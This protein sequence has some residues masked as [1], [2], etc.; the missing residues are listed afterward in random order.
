MSD[1]SK[2]SVLPFFAIKAKI[3]DEFMRRKDKVM[4]LIAKK[5]KTL[6]FEVSDIVKEAQNLIIL[7]R[8]GNLSEINLDNLENLIL[9]VNTTKDFL[10]SIEIIMKDQ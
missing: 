5:G 1:T 3:V 2:V 9:F 10:E 7:K 4:V 8:E 6:T